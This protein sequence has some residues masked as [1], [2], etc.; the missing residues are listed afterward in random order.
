MLVCYQQ[1]SI[2]ADM[3]FI[4]V[5]YSV[6]ASS[7]IL[8]YLRLDFIFSKKYKVTTRQVALD[9]AETPIQNVNKPLC[10][11]RWRPYIDILAQYTV[12]TCSTCSAL[13][14]YFFVHFVIVLMMSDEQRVLAHVLY[15]REPVHCSGLFRVIVSC[16]NH[17][18]GHYH[19]RETFRDGLNHAIMFKK[20]KILIFALNGV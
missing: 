14:A 9:G 2:N 16:N 10:F 20:Y 5:K 17:V 15:E 3:V 19:Y 18:I 13:R 12:R 6:E 7:F 1:P 8:F 4:N 11:W